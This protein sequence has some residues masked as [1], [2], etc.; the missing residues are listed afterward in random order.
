MSHLAGHHSPDNEMMWNRALIPCAWYPTPDPV[1]ESLDFIHGPPDG[2]QRLELFYSDGSGGAHSKD[3]MLRRCGWGFVGMDHYAPVVGKGGGL[4]GFKQTVPRAELYAVIALLRLR[5]PGSF[6]RIGVDCKY[7][8]TGCLR[9]PALVASKDNADLWEEYFLLISN[10]SLEVQI[11]KIFRS[12]CGLEDIASGRI[13][14]QDFL[15]NTC[16]DAF[17]RRGADAWAYPWD[18][19][20]IVRSL[21]GSTWRIGLRIA[22]VTLMAVKTYKGLLEAKPSSTQRIKRNEHDLLN[23]LGQVGHEMVKNDQRYFCSRCGLSCLYS[24]RQIRRLLKRGRCKAQSPSPP[25]VQPSPVETEDP[26][27]MGGMD[28]DGNF[29]TSGSSQG[30]VVSTPGQEHRLIDGAL[31]LGQGGRAVHSSHRM[32]FWAGVYYCARCGSWGISK[33]VRLA[34][35]CCRRPTPAGEAVLNNISRQKPPA[36]RARLREGRSLRPIL[37]TP[38]LEAGD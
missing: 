8:V 25:E 9:S 10:K 31:F 4:P 1:N 13:S 34:D 33:V 29:G 21:R 32:M 28:L 11:F 6:T 26:F 2:F 35:P 19:E 12:H 16:A 14:V 17:A 36:P 7:I 15:G 24:K 23:E 20:Q 5:P 30:A 3:P 38:G 22:T 18:L 37:V 27:D